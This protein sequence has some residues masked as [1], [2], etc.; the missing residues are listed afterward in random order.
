MYD[1]HT[2]AY[3]KGENHV[4]GCPEEDL[5]CGV[6]SPEGSKC[7]PHGACEVTDLGNAQ[8]K[9]TCMSGYRPLDKNTKVCDTGES[10]LT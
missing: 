3:A 1:L 10:W 5:V 7:G 4:D 2:G 9:C 6:N 8:F